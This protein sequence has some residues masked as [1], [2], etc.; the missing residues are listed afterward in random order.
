MIKNIKFQ[1]ISFWISILGLECFGL[2]QISSL[3]IRILI[4]GRIGAIP[5]D[6][7][8]IGENI[9]FPWC[10]ID[11]QAKQ[12]RCVGAKDLFFTFR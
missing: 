6:E 11:L 5:I 3:G 9:I 12:I 4:R 8:L 2:F 10:L 7:D 1:I